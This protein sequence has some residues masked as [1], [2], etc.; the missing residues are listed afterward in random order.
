MY[1][2]GDNHDI[3][4]HNNTKIMTIITYDNHS[5]SKFIRGRAQ[6]RVSYNEVL[7]WPL[8]HHASALVKSVTPWL[9]VLAI[10]W[11]I[12]GYDHQL[13]VSVPHMVVLFRTS[14]N[15]HGWCFFCDGIFT[16]M[17]RCRLV[18]KPYMDRMLYIKHVR[19]GTQFCT[20]MLVNSHLVE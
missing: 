19:Q 2:G 3:S 18:G 4:W 17:N 16:Y 10:N 8:N 1:S 11:P 6:L 20:P 12:G 14:N 5:Q 9:R 7:V 13:L 15:C